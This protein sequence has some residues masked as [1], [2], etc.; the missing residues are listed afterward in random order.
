[1]T[2][3]NCITRHVEMGNFI[4]RINLVPESHIRKKNSTVGSRYLEYSMSRFLFCLG[5]FIQSLGHF[6][7]DQ[8]KKHTVFLILISRIFACVEKIFRSLEQF[9]LVISNFSQS[10][11]NLSGKFSSQISLFLT[12]ASRIT[13]I[14]PARTN[15]K[16]LK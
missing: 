3:E 1:M 9:S 16:T 13:A 2:H 15:I 12:P 6:A 4:I 11:Q 10:F 8:S 7:L 14:M 5:I